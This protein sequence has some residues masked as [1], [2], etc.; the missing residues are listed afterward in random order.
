VKRLLLFVCAIILIL[1]AVLSLWGNRILARTLDAQLADL[2]SRELGLPVTLAPM[3]ARLLQLTARSPKLIM[4]DPD[5]PAIVATDVEVSLAWSDLLDREIRL[6]GARASSLMVHPSRW[7]VTGDP[8]PQDYLF[9]EPWLPTRLA[10]DAGRYV[11]EQGVDYPLQQLRWQRR[12]G[13]ASLAWSMPT[14]RGV[15]ALSVEAKSLDQVLRLVGTR[16]AL[17]VAATDDKGAA[18]DDS[19]ISLSADLTPGEHSGYQLDADIQAGGI[20][21]RVETANHTAWELP[22]ESTTTIDT[23]DAAALNE[24][25]KAYTRSA[26]DEDTTTRLSSTLPRLSLP[27]HRGNVAIGELRLGD[28]LGKNTAFTFNTS[29]EGVNISSLSSEGP[30]GVLQGHADL[31][32]SEDG[33]Q[34]A[35]DA[36]MTAR[37]ADSSIAAHYMTA[38]WLWRSGQLRLTGKGHSWGTL[39][40]SLDGEIQLSG[41]HSARVQTPV[42]I[43]ARLANRSGDLTLDD[44]NVQLGKASIQASMVLS[45]TEQRHL[46]VRLKAEQ[47]DL[48]FLFEEEDVTPQAGIALPEFLLALPGVDLDW[49]LELN[50]LELPGLSVATSQVNVIRNS[51]HNTLTAFATGRDQGTVELVL[52]AKLDPGKPTD[53]TM[54]TIISKVSLPKLFQQDNQALDSRS[55]GTISFESHGNGLEQLF[56]A[57]RGR[58]Q[59]QVE[60]RRDRDWERPPSDDDQ[61]QFS[62]D[63][64]LVIKDKRI[65]GLEVSQLDIESFKQDIT[66]T[67]SMVSQ[68]TP[69]L[70]ADF[71]SDRLDLNQLLG[72]GPESSTAAQEQNPLELL[73]DMDPLKMS[74]RARSVSLLDTQL[75]NVALEL[76]SAP[77]T[78]SVDKLNFSV[79]GG[80]LESRGQIAWH[81]QQAEF[82]LDAKVTNFDLDDFLIAHPGTPGVPVSGSAQLK[83]SGAST[84]ELLSNLVGDI[85]LAA[86][87]AAATPSPSNRRRLVMTARRTAHGMEARISRF[88]W[89]ESELSGKLL[90]NNTEP[91]SIDLEIN[92]GALNLLPWEQVQDT[93]PAADKA[94]TG[95]SGLAATSAN[96]VGRIL[97]SPMHALTATREAEPGEKFFSSEPLPLDL[98]RK[99]Q[100]R[101][102]GSLGSLTSSM[103][104]ARD[105]SFDA[106][107][108][109]QQLSLQA[110]AGQLN[111]GAA[112]VELKLNAAASP[113]TAELTSSFSELYRDADKSSYPRSGF[114]A[115]NSRGGSLAEMAANLNGLAYAK[116]GRGP[117]DFAN[118]HLLTADVGGA[119]FEALIPG[120]EKKPPE[121]KCGVTLGIFK[122]GMGITPYGYAARTREANLI[123]RVEVDF[124]KEMLE[125]QFSSSNRAGVGISV[126]SVFSNTVRIKGP[127]TDP[128]IVPRTTSI[129]WRGWA[130]FMTAG[131]SVVGESVLKRTLASSNPCETIDEQIREEHCAAGQ[132]AAASPLVCPRT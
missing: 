34:L 108:N 114:L 97:L 69:W 77:N 28:E 99:N 15:V 52:N 61:L 71:E 5:N 90:I 107:L 87:S 111:S 20:K 40:N 8:W 57:M 74:L 129:L 7:P 76:T 56:K 6:R 45:G 124:K 125:M 26:E 21:A 30:S 38:D 3:Q 94:D 78:F 95:V 101:V 89:G 79:L 119:L 82:S 49:Q 68:R 47:M 106:E 84:A 33:W 58:A 115:V 9:L 24:L 65:L 120:I 72:I 121:L 100:G 112:E 29:A 88:Q 37:E 46:R 44:I 75:S 25:I 93:A 55:T 70:I 130:A 42:T 63:A 4:G 122:D 23:V 11:D 43:E 96:F 53:L 13:G 32:S 27:E 67:L 19:R 86:S 109:D 41:S 131:M 12:S 105:I 92:G 83:S 118:T 85:D 102:H 98:V 62:G 91:T 116:L 126:G 128:K 117:I 73:R 36:R 64:R 60:Y 48:G 127:I 66:G 22:A 39:L 80:E 54:H 81:K 104:V 113:P 10:L 35:L 18:N 59:L 17:T 14:E 1:V 132:P 103:L 16:L 2:L 50:G 51:E 31:A 110:R 123:G